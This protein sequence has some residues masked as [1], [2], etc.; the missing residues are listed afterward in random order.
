M[1]KFITIFLLSFFIS[2]NVFAKNYYTVKT[3]LKNKDG[4]IY[5]IK[6]PLLLGVPIKLDRSIRK[7]SGLAQDHCKQFSKKSFSP[8]EK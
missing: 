8:S 4:A 7:A 2:T 5:S 1:F 3:L 6:R